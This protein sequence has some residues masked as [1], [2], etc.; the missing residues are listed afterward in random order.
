MSIS[1]MI[2]IRRAYPWIWSQSSENYSQEID[3]LS[4]HVNAINKAVTVK[5]G[6]FYFS[7]SIINR[8][9]YTATYKNKKKTF[10]MAT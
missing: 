9:T 10:K 1:A 3:D 5:V 7:S 8:V 2:Q 4:L 6:G